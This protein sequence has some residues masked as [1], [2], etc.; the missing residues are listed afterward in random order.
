[1]TGTIRSGEDEIVSFLLQFLCMCPLILLVWSHEEGHC[2]CLHREFC[3][4]FSCQESVTKHCCVFRPNKSWLV[5]IRSSICSP[6]SRSTVFYDPARWRSVC[7][8]RIEYTADCIQNDSKYWAAFERRTKQNSFTV[9]I[10]KKLLMP[11][12]S[13]V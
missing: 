3:L 7:S 4:V 10:N 1:M 13:S 6:L 8:I 5:P 11:I 9:S 2:T 12:R